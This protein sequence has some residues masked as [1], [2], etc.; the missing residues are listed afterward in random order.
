M[1]IENQLTT[2][3]YKRYLE[4]FGP[5]LPI[6]RGGYRIEYDSPDWPEEMWGYTLFPKRGEINYYFGQEDDD[7]NEEYETDRNVSIRK[8]SEFIGN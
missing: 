8:C 1:S 6:P 4:L 2:D 5:N 3:M 7:P